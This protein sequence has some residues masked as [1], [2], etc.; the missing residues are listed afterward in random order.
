MDT[1]NLLK[2][3]NA[4]LPTH[5]DR[6][7]AQKEYVS[8]KRDLQTMCDRAAYWQERNAGYSLALERI[9]FDIT[10][11]E[12]LSVPPTEDGEMISWRQMI[13]SRLARRL[14]GK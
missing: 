14:E 8:L 3:V 10:G 1:P 2:A 9:A 4:L 12:A 13:L 11:D 6:I 5:G 7:E